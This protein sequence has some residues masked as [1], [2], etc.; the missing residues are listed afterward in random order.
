[1]AWLQATKKLALEYV[2]LPDESFAEGAYAIKVK[3]GNLQIEQ[4][5]TFMVARK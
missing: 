3:S 5:A 1:M 2:Q 4:G